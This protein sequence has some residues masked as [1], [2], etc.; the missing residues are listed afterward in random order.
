MAEF[1]ANMKKLPLE[2]GQMIF[3]IL[4]TEELEQIKYGD[5]PK[6]QSYA[7]TYVIGSRY[8]YIALLNYFRPEISNYW[9][10]Y[11]G[12]WRYND[13]AYALSEMCGHFI[14][15]ANYYSEHWPD[16]VD[17]F[18]RGTRSPRAYAGRWEMIERNQ[19]AWRKIAFMLFKL[20][21]ALIAKPHRTVEYLRKQYYDSK[22]LPPTK[23]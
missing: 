4:I 13:I 17:E 14:S 22:C 7:P 5:D 20:R 10:E 21:V 18:N 15:E 1:N 12:T 2:I 11:A 6:H 19:N 9:A 3:D 16:H 23:I 8:P